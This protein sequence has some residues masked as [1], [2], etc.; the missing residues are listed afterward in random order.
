MVIDDF[1]IVCVAVFPPEA[2][3]PLVV[4]SYAVLSFAVSA[5]SFEAITRRDEK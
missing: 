5:E 1:D 4:D 2:D 3:A